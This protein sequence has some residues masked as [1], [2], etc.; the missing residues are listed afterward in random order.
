MKHGNYFDVHALQLQKLQGAMIDQHDI[1]IYSPSDTP[2]KKLPPWQKAKTATKKIIEL[3]F[4]YFF[5]MNV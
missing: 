5:K 1:Y 2:K 4:T 3:L